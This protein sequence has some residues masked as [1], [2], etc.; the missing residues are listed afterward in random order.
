MVEINDDVEK[1]AIE[2]YK[3]SL[4]FL[5]ILERTLT[6]KSKFNNDLLYSMSAMC[7]EKQF[8]ALIA[9]HGHMAAHHMPL[10]LYKD[11]HQFEPRLTPEM[12]DTA[13]Y[14]TKFESICSLDGFGYKTPSDEDLTRIITGLVEVNELIKT[15]III[16]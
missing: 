13:R 10:A 1:L 16:E 11:A 9:H 12:K 4:N 15:I 2:A 14:L 5:A 7:F 8:V 6:K 3:E